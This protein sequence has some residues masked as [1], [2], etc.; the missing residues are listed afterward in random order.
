[1]RELSLIEMNF[2]SGAGAGSDVISTSSNG[3]TVGAAVAA[4]AVGAVRGAAAGVRAGVVGA[5]VGAVVGAAVGIYEAL[6]PKQQ[7]GNGY[8]SDGGNY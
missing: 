6:N 5:G 2:I 1:M 4:A 8:C 3:A 7:D